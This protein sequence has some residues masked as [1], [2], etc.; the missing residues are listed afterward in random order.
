MKMMQT[1]FSVLSLQWTDTLFSIIVRSAEGIIEKEI[2]E[3]EWNRKIE[4]CIRAADTAAMSQEQITLLAETIKEKLNVATI[5]IRQSILTENYIEKLAHNLA[6]N[7]EDNE[8]ERLSRILANVLHFLLDTLYE[9]PEFNKVV[10]NILEEI[11]HE[12]KKL[13]RSLNNHEQRIR[14][15]EDVPHD[16]EEFLE[17][18]PPLR[19]SQKN[20]PFVFTY[21]RLQEIWGREGEIEKLT[22]FAEDKSRRFLFCAISGPAGMGKS[23]LV[24]YFGREYQKK[25]DWLV[26]MLDRKPLQELCQKRNWSTGKNILL[27]IDYA[28][29]H[30]QLVNLLSKLSRLKEDGC[31]QKIRVILIAREG[32]SPSMDTPYETEFP[33]WY[34][35]IINEDRTISEHLFL[36]E[37]INLKGLKIEECASLHNAFA[38]NHL[39]INVTCKDEEN[40]KQLIEQ[41]IMEDDGLVRPLYAL[42]VIDLYYRNPDVRSWNLTSLREQIYERDWKKWN[43]E[44]CGK[45][46]KRKAVFVALTNLL[47]YATIFGQWKSSITLPEPLSADCKTVFDAA[48]MEAIDV[49][50]KWFKVLTG[51]TVLSQESGEVVLVRLTP[52]MIGEFYVLKRLSSFDNDT[53]HSWAELVATQLVDC[54]DFFIRAIQDFGNDSSFNITF[55]TLF[56][57]ISK[58]LQK[59]DAHRSFASIME[60]FFRYYKGNMDSQEFERISQVIK[61]YIKL[62]ENNYA[63]AAELTLLYH[64]KRPH[65][66]LN[67]KERHFCRIN[68]L[69][70]KLP[71]SA[72]ITCSYISFLGDIAA[73][74]IGSHASGFSDS[75]IKKLESFSE[76]LPHWLNSPDSYEIRKAFIPVLIK[77]IKRAYDVQSWKKAATFRGLLLECV[78]ESREDDLVLDCISTYDGVITS[79]A[80]QRAG[81]LHDYVLN[82][83]SE[84]KEKAACECD[85]Q[86]KKEIVFFKNVID[87]NIQPSFNFVWIYVG[88][89]AMVTKN[90]FIYEC[91]LNTD[92]FDH[93]GKE[94]F[95][96]MLNKLQNVYNTYYNS[97]N[98]NILAWRA[99][100]A[101]NAFCDTKSDIIPA[102]IKAQCILK[103]PDL[104]V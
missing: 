67:A 97:K 64:E 57:M 8:T 20:T 56:S 43:V 68:Q 13:K 35:E 91:D 92:E 86:L 32:T 83:N 18:L 85:E 73:T 95:C 30:E 45:R 27:I 55:F 38:E 62:N 72:K 7:D 100:W 104:S 44:I 59:G 19:L 82:K 77:V 46:N 66:S 31:W 21:N 47:L 41:E 24:F 71:D 49:K 94:L 17:T 96:Y 40:I 84:S 4:E 74:K 101:L 36:N 65:M 34:S 3:V 42:F 87:S 80:K 12:Q 1:I 39:R 89:L 76:R 61:Q 53:L 25:K 70:A 15:L 2:R 81:L 28:N 78:L 50:R 22:A 58:L 60:A 11:G 10:A 93:Q 90:L 33:Q 99:S 5:D 48:N 75:Y 103:K 29:E 6:G 52:D 51:K 69:Y 9:C 26:S 37:F 54:K 79:L 14:F 63:C 88:K 102:S 23:K 16:V 98:S